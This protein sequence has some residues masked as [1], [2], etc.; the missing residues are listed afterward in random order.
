MSC[1]GGARYS[2]PKILQ[3][4]QITAMEDGPEETF[5]ASDAVEVNPFYK[6]IENIYV[7]LRPD[8]FHF[9]A[10][11]TNRPSRCRHTAQR[12]TVPGNLIGTNRALLGTFGL[13]SGYLAA[14]VSAPWQMS[15]SKIKKNFS[16]SMRKILHCNCLS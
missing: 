14:P 12:P 3:C 5:P 8:K 13:P 1:P 15:V 10:Q 16:A 9:R 2:A 4:R 7:F 11:R 6:P